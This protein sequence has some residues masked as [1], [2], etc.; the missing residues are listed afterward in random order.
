MKN[1]A[2]D[3]SAGQWPWGDCRADQKSI[4]LRIAASAFLNEI[5]SPSS[6]L[7][8]GIVCLKFF[9]LSI[10]HFLANINTNPV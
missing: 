8:R 1:M 10:C 2:P 7:T 6:T 4:D 5:S 3:I 9:S